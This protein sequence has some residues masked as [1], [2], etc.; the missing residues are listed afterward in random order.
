MFFFYFWAGLCVQCVQRNPLLKFRPF[1]SV[2]FD[3]E[4]KV[5][6]EF[7]QTVSGSETLRLQMVHEFG[8]AH[9]LDHHSQTLV[10]CFFDHLLVEVFGRPLR[11][12]KFAGAL[13][14]NNLVISV[15]LDD[16]KPCPGF[17]AARETVIKT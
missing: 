9:G 13:I 4:Y 12:G 15:P 2:A 7:I 6:I 16:K 10:F 8:A 3:T 14:D 1:E 17:G 11:S 5:G